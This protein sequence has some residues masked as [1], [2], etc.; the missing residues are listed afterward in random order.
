MILIYRSNKEGTCLPSIPHSGKVESLLQA[1]F[2]NFPPDVPELLHQMDNVPQLKRL[3]RTLL[4][5]ICVAAP[6]TSLYL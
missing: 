6:D 5:H 2:H 4:P 1:I 3:L